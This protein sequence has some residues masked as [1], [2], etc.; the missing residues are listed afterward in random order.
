MQ[1]RLAYAGDGGMHVS[2]NTFSRLEEPRLRFGTS[3]NRLDQHASSDISV[4]YHTS[5]T[6]NNHVKLT[7][8]KPDTKYY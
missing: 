6:Y 1:L 4:T 2:W 5:T 8:L 7:G 3:P